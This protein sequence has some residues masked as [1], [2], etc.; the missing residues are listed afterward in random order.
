[1]LLLKVKSNIED[2]LS[3]MA[4][5]KLHNQSEKLLFGLVNRETSWYFINIQ[6]DIANNLEYQNK[7]ICPYCKQ[8][9]IYVKPYKRNCNIKVS[10]YFKHE[11]HNEMNKNCIFNHLG[12][13]NYLSDRISFYKNREFLIKSILTNLPEKPFNIRIPID[14]NLDMKNYKI[15]YFYKS[16]VI[17]NYTLKSKLSDIQF[18]ILF[19]T[20]EGS[21]G[22]ILN[23]NQD[24]LNLCINNNLSLINFFEDEPK[25]SDIKLSST[26]EKL[27]T[28]KYQI[29]LNEV[30]VKAHNEYACTLEE[31]ATRNTINQIENNIAEELH[32]TYGMNRVRNGKG[33]NWITRNGRI[34]ESI[35]VHI[36]EKDINI[37]RKL[38]QVVINKFKELGYTVISGYYNNSSNK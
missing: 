34:C 21:L 20:S 9:L 31:I 4:E 17:Y 23:P 38:P 1:M 13:P 11:G 3:L 27:N 24:D 5:H 25:E 28:L 16:V 15:N 18:D 35:W 6:S 2:L 32:R 19:N 22:F 26:I 12:N 10:S 7:I 30:I 37:N 29:K 33:Y 36:K 14:Y 8:K